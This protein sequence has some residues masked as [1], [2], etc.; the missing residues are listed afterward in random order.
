MTRLKRI[1]ND[2][3]KDDIFY[4]DS[5]LNITVVCLV[6]I[7]LT[8]IYTMDTITWITFFILYIAFLIMAI[9]KEFRIMRLENRIELQNIKDMIKIQEEGNNYE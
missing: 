2:K 4:L 7:T 5:I 9:L 3:I 1:S 8:S 6:I